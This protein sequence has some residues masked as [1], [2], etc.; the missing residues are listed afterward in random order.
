LF[1]TLRQQ[2]EENAMGLLTS[3]PAVRQVETDRPGL[4]AFDLVGHI[5]AADV[6]NFYGLLE[7]AYT[8]HPTIDVLVRVVDQGETD[9]DDA[10]QQTLDEA[11]S[12]AATHVRRCA[13]IGSTRAIP[14]IREFFASSVEVRQ[15]ADKEEK[16][17]WEWVGGRPVGD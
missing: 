10:S 3:V 5:S 12:H 9:P 13:L 15:F 1:Q 17:A 6:E 11:R 7:A 8:L 4:Y 14:E 16:A 2:F